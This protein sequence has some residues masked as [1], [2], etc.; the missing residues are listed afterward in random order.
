MVVYILI[1]YDENKIRNKPGTPLL[2]VGRRVCYHFSV[3]F[4]PFSGSLWKIIRQRPAIICPFSLIIDSCWVNSP[5]SLPRKWGRE[6]CPG[7]HT[8]DFMVPYLK[9]SS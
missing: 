2:A 3:I 7:V 8:I 6:F 9:L 4:N 1:S 5:Q